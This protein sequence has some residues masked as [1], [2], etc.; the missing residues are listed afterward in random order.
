MINEEEILK[1]W[2]DHDIFKKSEAKPSTGEFVFYDGPPFAT[3]LPHY[4][5][6]LAGTMKDAIP[7]YQTMKGKRV[8][9][10][11]GWDCH[12]LPLENIIEAE[13]GLKTKKDILDL[14]IG[15][16][17]EAAQKAVL[18]YAD[19]W[20]KI[21]P[22]LGRWADMDNDYK[23]MDASYTESV[24]WIFKTLY[25]K[26]LIY[27][28]YK[29]MQICPRCE[30]TLSN[31][32]V[33]QG[34]KDVKDLSVTV[35][36]ELI[37]EPKKFLLAWTTT[38]WT[39]P[40]NV[41]LAINPEVEYAEVEGQVPGNVYIVAV[42]R[43]EKVF[44][45]DYKIIKKFLG[46]ELVGKKYKTPFSYYLTEG[47]VYGADFVTTED[48]TGIV[49]IA[50]AFGSDDYELLKR[51]NLPFIQHVGMDGRFKPEVTDWAGKLVKPKD[52]PEEIDVEIIKYLAKK[53]LLFAK[54]KITH[55]YPHCW[56][57]D[58]PL[59]NYA[60]NSWFVKVT[61]FKDDL[62]A[63]NKQI[64]WVP[65]HVK[66]GRFGKW[67]EG[68][69]DWAI[70]RSRFWG[71]PLPVWK[72]QDCEAVKVIG[73]LTELE[74][75][76]PAA[77][78]NYW[79]VRHGTATSNMEHRIS[80]KVDN[81]DFLVPEGVAGAKE[82]AQK[83][84][85]E[86]IDL[87][88]SSDFIR[89]RETA[90]IIAQELNLNPKDIIYDARLR[91]VD[92]GDLEGQSW[93]SYQD[94]FLH[95]REEL[96]TKLPN[97]ESLI[98]VRK[99]MVE[100]VLDLEAKYQGKNILV[101]SHGLPAFS[102]IVGAAGTPDEYLSKL[103]EEY[104]PI[105]HTEPIQVKLNLLPRNSLGGL[106][107]HRPFIDEV[108][109]KCACGGEMTRVPEVFDCWFESGSMPYGQN[110]YLGEAKENFD[111]LKQVGFPA[112]FIAEGLDQTRGWFYSMLVLGVALFGKTPY[113]N[114]IVN[115]LVLAE[116]G[117]K[118]SKKLKN[119]P[120]PLEVV[121]KYGADALRFYL[122]SAPAVRAE[123][124]NFFEA[125][126]AE[127][128][129]KIVARL[130]NV[131]NFYQTYSSDDVGNKSEQKNVL[132]LWI[133][134]RL[135]QTTERVSQS[136]DKYELDRA[137]RELDSLIDDFSNWYLRRSRERFKSEDAAD[138]E[139]AMITTK[140][141]LRE[142]AKLMAPFTPFMAEQIFQALR[143]DGDPESVH[144][145]NWPEVGEIEDKVIVGMDQVRNLVELALAARSEAKVKVR[146]PLA[147]LKLKEDLRPEFIPILKDELN[148][149]EVIIDRSLALELEFDFTITPELKAEGV[150]RELVRQAQELRKQAGCSPDEEI[151]L[152]V[153]GNEP[154]QTILNK[155]KEEIKRATR[156]K[157]VVAGAS[158]EKMAVDEFEFEL[159]V[160]RA[161]G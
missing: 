159:A 3:G 92:A 62:V 145:A 90:E 155:F 38:P 142:T 98:D 99:R 32:E 15:K 39:L 14:G 154:A 46:Q 12:G 139:A 41:A 113:K 21:V 125:G 106:D 118:M 87:I 153:S 33:N 150:M 66:E 18:R 19:D 123:D 114:V 75:H 112:D 88:I 130:M 20:K 43:I 86:K 132:D 144:L 105:K 117:Q 65:E 77:K 116:D 16:F 27:E 89:T 110:N 22:R 70:S 96:I 79:V 151:I 91:E 35:E 58:T 76:L 5:H 141:V 107:L 78:N 115:G 55:S 67:L 57:C 83:L 9:R 85:V 135:N 104:G 111:P 81:Q 136:L 10:R 158:G 13:L 50:P 124:L 121:N 25:D 137:A 26:G 69:R 103:K 63:A 40:G 36:L 140:H 73:N 128:S 71:A 102:L 30:T 2:Q 80:S 143:H 93:L 64:G 8:N 29:S 24:W 53:D 28:G 1:F 101:V 54:E 119:Y 49:H 11:W 161:N 157:E 95:R 148:V 126:V 134:S 133:V 61:E 44:G 149:K 56:R 100:T 48:G 146:Q 97:G 156:A 160:K 74:Q 17:N 47:Q 45:S 52:N 152:V 37:G 84:L 138:K 120:D 7:R 147:V 68:A 42:P 34:Y 82:A 94:F 108:K 60:T 129:R 131:L 72:C 51:E 109:L 6:I 122:L 59:L 31:F 23:T 4:G 127:V